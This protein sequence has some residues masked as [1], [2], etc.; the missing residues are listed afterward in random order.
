MSAVENL[1]IDGQRVAS[2]EGRTFETVNPATGEVFRTVAEAGAEDA[3][4]AVRAAA[5][6]F[7]DWGA[8]TP[9]QRA[10]VLYRWADLIEANV[11]EL[12]LLETRDMGMALGDARWCAGNAAAVMRYYAGAV[13]KF[14]AP[15]S[16]STATGSCSPSASRSG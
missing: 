8:R 5:R 10:K 4:R 3:D 1:V 11:D 6:A 14:G 9:I 12:G 2:A 13:D 7:E 15:R 16:P